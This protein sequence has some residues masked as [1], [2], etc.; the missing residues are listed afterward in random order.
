MASGMK[1]HD[2]FLYFAYAWLRF[3]STAP[4]IDLRIRWTNKSDV[5]TYVRTY[6]YN[7]A[8]PDS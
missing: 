4:D 5:S 2:G 6:I 7:C 3:K 1:S 8:C